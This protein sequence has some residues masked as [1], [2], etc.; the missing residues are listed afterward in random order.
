MTMRMVARLTAEDLDILQRV[1]IVNADLGFW[2]ERYTIRQGT[3]T[4]VSLQASN[5]PMVAAL[6]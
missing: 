1:S 3:S 4:H 6:R 5:T 2:R